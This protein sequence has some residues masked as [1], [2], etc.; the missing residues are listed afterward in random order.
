MLAQSPAKNGPFRSAVEPAALREDSSSASAKGANWSAGGGASGWKEKGGWGASCRASSPPEAC[1]PAG[2]AAACLLRR[3][4]RPISQAPEGGRRR[5]VNQVDFAR[6]LGFGARARPCR[7][8]RRAR[9]TL[10]PG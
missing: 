10:N 3:Q 1:A 5:G 4:A 6:V 9:V 7:N 8:R 2:S